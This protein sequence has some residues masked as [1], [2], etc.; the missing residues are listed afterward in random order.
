MW[1][2]FYSEWKWKHFFALVF[3]WIFQQTWAH[4]PILVQMIMIRI[5]S[6]TIRLTKVL[7]RIISCTRVFIRVL[8]SRASIRSSRKMLILFILLV[9]LDENIIDFE[10]RKVK[11]RR[12]HDEVSSGK[13]RHPNFIARKYSKDRFDFDKS[14]DFYTKWMNSFQELKCPIRRSSTC[15]TQIKSLQWVLATATRWFRNHHHQH[16]L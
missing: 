5:K 13:Y 16:T 12:A 15:S 11:E 9:S 7:R 14:M 4:H 1:I 3:S 6:A 2:N 8:D 10:A